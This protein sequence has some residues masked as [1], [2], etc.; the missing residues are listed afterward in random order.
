MQ[1]IK[2]S[3]KLF[4]LVLSGA[5]TATTRKELKPYTIGDAEFINPEN[6]EEKIK[7]IINSVHLTT[8]NGII[9]ND[10]LYHNEGYNSSSD[11]DE[12]LENIYGKMEKD[13]E[14]T[15][16]YFKVLK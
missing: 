14:M 8:W 3:K 11:L 2:L 15:I 12:A 1:Q 6:P 16:I 13:Q 10:S 4:P 7:I 9:H 5:K